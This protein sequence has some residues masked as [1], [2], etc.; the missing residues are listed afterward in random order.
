MSKT[1]ENLPDIPQ[2]VTIDNEGGV[3][4][5]QIEG[6]VDGTR[7]YFRARGKFWTLNIGVAPFSQPDW[8]WGQR[9]S[10]KPFEAG[11]MTLAEARSFLFEAIALYRQGM[12]G[13]AQEYAAMREIE[14][15]LRLEPAFDELENNI[16]FKDFIPKHR[17]VLEKARAEG[18][19]PQ[20]A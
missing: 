18:L 6:H 1:E 14:T 10:H 20:A 3:A 13:N 19:I 4:P 15:A 11:F 2:G 8:F 5:V 16:K 7:F 9:Y 12:S 17:A